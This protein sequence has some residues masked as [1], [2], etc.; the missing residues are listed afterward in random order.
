MSADRDAARFPPIAFYSAIA[1]GHV[2]LLRHVVQCE[3]ARVA[4]G[5]AESSQGDPAC[6]ARCTSTLDLG[7]GFPLL[8]GAAY[9][10]AAM[11]R[12]LLNGLG[13]NAA[14]NLFGRASAAQKIRAPAPAELGATA[15]HAAALRVYRTFEASALHELLA[16]TEQEE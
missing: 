13:H 5:T 4:A 8:F 7:W 16:R 9:G 3:N 15:L 10:S 14:F 2:E 11:T 6:V 1:S 12:A